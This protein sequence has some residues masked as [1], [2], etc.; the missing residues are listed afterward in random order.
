M[1]STLRN[2]VATIG[3]ALAAFVAAC[4]S[5]QPGEQQPPEIPPTIL[6]ASTGH[7]PAYP[8]ASNGTVF[9]SETSQSPVMSRRISGG[10]TT[11][12]AYHMGTPLG[13]AVHGPD[14]IWID[15]QLKTSPAGCTGRTSYRTVHRTTPSGATTLLGVGDDCHPLTTSAVVVAGEWAWWVSSTGGF[16]H[17]LQRSSLA[18]GTTTTMATST[19]PI[20]SLATDGSYV[21]WME[22][23]FADPSA[24]VRRLPLAGGTVTT[25]VSGFPS[26][27]GGIAVDGHSVFYTVAGYPTGDSLMAVPA[28][29]GEPVFHGLATNTPLQLAVDATRLYW[30]DQAGISALSLAGGPVEVLAT[31]PVR[32]FALS[33]R[34]ADVVWSEWRPELPSAGGAIRSVSEDGWFRHHI[35]PGRRSAPTARFRCHEHL[36]QPG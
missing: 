16:Q 31:A 26:R 14:V 6:F 9:W 27:N 28:A 18:G 22:N 20:V 24:A 1:H 34:D 23:F 5:E 15:G 32:P 35:V 4:G 36:V 21:Y 19:L 11:E 17:S 25:L 3:A 2:C 30:V 33:L 7:R 13:V 12:L 29:G 10:T 8:I